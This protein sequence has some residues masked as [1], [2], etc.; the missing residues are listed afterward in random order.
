MTSLK[1]CSFNV[2]GI[3]ERN[4]RRDIFNWLRKKKYDICL[5]QESHCTKEQEK[6]WQNEWG[7]RAY[8][9]SHTSNSRGV[10]TL[11][12]NTFK[13]ELHS[14]LSDSEGRYVILDC[15]ISGQRCVIANIYGPNEDE[16]LFFDMLRTKLEQFENSSFILGGDYNVVQDYILDTINI[17]NR[18][19]PNAHKS[20]INLRDELDLIDPWREEN[21]DAK[22]FTWHNSQNKQSRLDYFLISSDI[23]NYVEK[24]CI[25]PGYRSDHSVVEL[26]LNFG[27]QPKGRG[28]W[29]FN[30]SLLKDQRYVEEIKNCIKNTKQQYQIRNIQMPNDDP[31]NFNINSQLL[32]ETLK[33]E[34]RGKTIAY[35]SAKKKEAAKHEKE[36]DENIDRLHKLYIEDPTLENL[37]RLEEMKNEL[38]LLR[39]EK[40]EGIIMRAKAKWNLE[41]EKN[42]RYFCNLEKRHYQEKVISKLID[43]EGNE[44]KESKQILNEQKLYYQKLY[45]SHNPT[46][47]QELDKLFFDKQND[48]YILSNEEADS[49]ENEITPE[50]CY[51]ILKD[52]KANKSPGSDGF[53]T[54]F[55]LHFWNELKFIMVNSFKYAFQE[56]KMSDSQRL[57]VITCLPK[58]GKDKLYM[59]NWRPISLL[60]IDYKILSGVIANRIK[61][62]LGALISQCQKG[63]IEGRQIGECTRIVSDLIHY[64]KRSNKSGILLMIDFEKA[65]D[66]LEWSFVEKTLK[67]F[68]F[69][70]NIL[71]WVKCFYKDIESFVSNNGH[72]SDRFRLGRGVRQGDPLSPY[73]FILCTEILARTILSNS[74]I[75]GLKVDDSEFI[76]TQLADDTSFFLENNEQ[77]FKTCLQTLEKFSLIS[78]LKIN[79]SKTLAIKINL[80]AEVRYNLGNGKDI[81]WQNDGKFTLLGIKYDLD[82]ENFLQ[83]NYDNKVKEFEKMLN[84]WNTRNLTFYGKICI[85]KSLAL[86]KLVHLFSSIPNP[87]E[88]VFS[89]LE[90]LCFHFIWSGKS[91]KIKRSTMYNSYENGGF[92]V[93]NIKCFCMAQKIVWIKKLLDDQCVADWKTLFLSTVEKYG[94][95]Y[96]WLSKDISP[97]FQKILNPFWQDVYKIWVATP[98]TESGDPKKEPLF[99]NNLI[100]VN[101]RP[102]YYRE[103]HMK[104][105]MHLNDII[106]DQG[107]F[108]SWEIF[109][110]KFNIENQC[111]RYQSLLHAIPRNWKKRIKEMGN[112]LTNVKTDKIQKLLQ[113]KKPSKPFYQE[114]M[115]NNISEPIHTQDKWSKILNTQISKKEWA[116]Y[117][118]LPFQCTTTMKLRFFQTKILHRTLPLNKWLYKCNISATPNCTF[119]LIHAETIEHLLFDCNV[120]KNIW[121]KLSDWLK[122]ILPHETFDSLNIKD[123]LFGFNSNKMDL[124][125]IKIFCKKFLYNCKINEQTPIFEQLLQKIRYEI[126]LEKLYTPDKEF[127]KKW[128]REILQALNLC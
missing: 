112:K 88:H 27:C 58:P 39:E 80:G 118:I 77:S 75:K 123:A 54:E 126:K 53:T 113:L 22:V 98:M 10:V 19:N 115:R 66:S 102:I 70:K 90:K 94:G 71:K 48:F 52:M 103:W 96:M 78:G 120:S 12:N 105:V 61:K 46:T 62:H 106:D 104:G 84:T 127:R 99:H 56:G 36:I 5:L 69:G 122:N 4:K 43:N 92:R 117:Y 87:P 125:C 93:P 38:K 59:K 23:F 47:D 86:S 8:Y 74:D 65:F 34:I 119:C 63:F 51:R 31:N 55:Y 60:N 111:F 29:K 67:H 41:G 44:I 13:Y 89:K 79:F 85:I 114:L 30:N 2:R 15:S 1:I 28:L 101:H 110:E 11:V 40:I 68:N 7:Y 37:T 9:S 25:K 128:R 95:N 42:T 57:G 76:L 50:E 81:Q 124:E 97:I 16:P 109:S 32:F 18:N 82:Q 64:L 100:K 6:T 73:L 116:Y 24:T 26:I 33:F 91:E 72:A 17:R 49:I 108:Y 3:K 35:S 14:I 45:T 83:C 21:P 121:F 20:V 107:N